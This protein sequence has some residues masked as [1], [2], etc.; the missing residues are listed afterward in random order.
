MDKPSIG[1]IID[2]KDLDILKQ[3]IGTINGCEAKIGTITCKGIK[4]FGERP[5]L[6]TSY[7]LY[8]NGYPSEIIATDNIKL[9]IDTFKKRIDDGNFRLQETITNSKEK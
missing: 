3:C 5:G 8:I 4:E 7:I 2:P 6:H 9:A 1:E